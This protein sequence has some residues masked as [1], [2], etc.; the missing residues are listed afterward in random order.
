MAGPIFGEFYSNFHNFVDLIK[1]DWFF[2]QE[3]VRRCLVRRAEIA[4][5]LNFVLD[6]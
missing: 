5:W 6:A 1:M 2:V 3:I 4:I